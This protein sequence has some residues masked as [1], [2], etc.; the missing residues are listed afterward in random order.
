MVDVVYNHVGWPNLWAMIDRKYYFRLTP[1]FEYLNFSGVGND[2]RTE[3]PM[4]RRLI[5][6]SIVHWV[7]EFK[8]DGFRWDLAELVDMETLMESKR[9]A[10]KINPK[11]LMVSEPW[12]F[13]GNH[14]A[15]L[16]GTGWAAW[17]DDFRYTAQDYAQGRPNRESMARAIAGSTDIWT[18]NPLQSVNYVESHDDMVFADMLSHRPDR[19]GRFP[20][21]SEIRRN[22]LAGTLVFTSLGI[23]MINNGQEFHRSKHGIRNTYNQGDRVNAIKWE[24]RD[25]PLNAQVLAYY[26]DLIALRMS[27]EG[28]AFRVNETPPS[29]Y[30]R[31]LMPDHDE[32][33]LG[34]I[35]NHPRV[36]PGN[37]FIVL[38][39][40]TEEPQPFEFEL[41]AGGWRIIGD[42]KSIDLAGLPDYDVIV[43]PRRITL[44]APELRS[45]IL[46]D[47][48]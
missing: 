22:K 19:D 15:Q 27:D 32:R 24:I 4:A 35:I 10:E 43:G 11:V 9:E 44:R 37:G 6:E 28:R 39:N 41:P 18:A 21:E 12:S 38:H 3:A 42:G 8:V 2:F 23:P 45:L 36:H 1:D 29:G 31:W 46:M 26:K 25:E 20:T 5:V 7:E 30:L 48:F 40:P 14:K 13:R 33:L 16:R 34:M 17:N 47:G